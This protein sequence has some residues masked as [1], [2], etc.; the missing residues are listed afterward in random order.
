MEKQF[1]TL[2]IGDGIYGINILGIR[3]INYTRMFTPVPLSP[4]HIVGLLNLRGQI[5]TVWDMG[6][7]LGYPKRTMKGESSL[8]VMKINEELSAVA[9]K[10]G[11]ETHEAQV[12]LF[13]DRIGDVIS[14]EENEIAPVPA[15]ADAQVAKFLEGVVRQDETLVGLINVPELLRYQ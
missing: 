13:V 15:H 8:L 10:H 12:G 11:I 2:Y 3:E 14:C 1:M 7:P 4:D 9:R 5:V 6:I